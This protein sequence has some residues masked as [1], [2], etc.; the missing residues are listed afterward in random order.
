MMK[1]TVFISC[2]QDTAREKEFGEKLVEYFRNKGFETYFAEHIHSSK[3]LLQSILDALKESEYFIAWNPFRMMNG[4]VGSLFVQQEIAVAAYLGLPSLYFHDKGVDK[5]AGMSGAL[6]LNGIEIDNTSR[7]E[8]ELDKLTRKWNN[9][10]KNQLFLK[11]GNEHKD[12]PLLSYPGSPPSNW[13]HL[14]VWNGCGYKHAKNCRAYADRIVKTNSRWDLSSEYKQ[15]L[16][17]A[18]TGISAINITSKK[19]R[20][21]DA[22]WTLKGNKQWRFHSIQTSSVYSYPILGEGVYEIYYLVVSDNMPDAKLEVKLKLEND[23][24]IILAQKRL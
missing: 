12:I 1:S 3:P 14:V 4:E 9:A 10:S 18:G 5:T 22:I 21:A 11:F 24:A 7:L 20:D 13:Y 2:G 6:H 8:D 23:L 19:K 16:I 15:E 17:W